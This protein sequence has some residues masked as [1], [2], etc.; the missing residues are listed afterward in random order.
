[1]TYTAPLDIAMLD[2]D[3]LVE[4][5]RKIDAVTEP[6]LRLRQRLQNRIDDIMR[7]EGIEHLLLADNTVGASRKKRAAQ[8]DHVMLDTLLEIVP[9]EVAVRAGALA[10]AY[11]ETVQ[12]DHERKW[13][14]AKAK[15]LKKFGGDAVTE[16]IERAR[17]DGGFSN[18][19]IRPRK[20]D[21]S[22]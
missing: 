7:A 11:T 17:I 3:G 5:A 14:V 15:A 9:E 13:N 19:M 4:E 8:Y 21:N 22:G 16:V 6:L 2:T 18:A 12:I 1:M 20:E 10:A